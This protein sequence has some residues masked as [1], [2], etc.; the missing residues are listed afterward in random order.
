MFNIQNIATKLVNYLKPSF[1]PKKNRL[2]A[3]FNERVPHQPVPARREEP[4][5]LIQNVQGRTND[6]LD[7][8]SIDTASTTSSERTDAS[9]DQE[10]YDFS[11][12]EIDDQLPEPIEIP[13]PK[14]V[15][16]ADGKIIRRTQVSSQKL[17]DESGFKNVSSVAINV[18][19]K[20]TLPTVKSRKPE[21][22]PAWNIS[23]KVRTP[24]YV[25]MNR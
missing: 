18:L 9:P 20:E 5:L 13:D 17:F 6:A 21:P 3:M 15:D 22:K 14:P 4:I 16:Y 12:Q 2:A 1:F 10:V 11:F 8:E 23:S 25:R 7:I 24:S 19:N